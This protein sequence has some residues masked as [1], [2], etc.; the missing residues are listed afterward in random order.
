MPATA[1]PAHLALFSRD[2]L[3]APIRSGCD[4][5]YRALPYAVRALTVFL[6]RDCCNYS[7]GMCRQLQAHLD[8]CRGTQGATW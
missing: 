7:K 4:I 2:G 6:I 1:M 5:V 3:A 8:Q